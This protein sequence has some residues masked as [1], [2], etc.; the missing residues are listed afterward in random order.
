MKYL[1]RYIGATYSNIYQLSI[2]T[3]ASATLPNPDMPT[4]IPDMGAEHPK[5]DVEIAHLKKNNIYKAIHQKLRNRDVY[6]TG[7]HK[8][9][10]IILSQTNDQLQYKASSDSTLQV[11][12]SGWYPN[13]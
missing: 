8:I 6:E 3:N 11:V 5:R 12:K 2:M 4:I 9:Y 1:E 10:N 7:T 13:S